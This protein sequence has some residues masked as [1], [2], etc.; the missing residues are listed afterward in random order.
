AALAD[1][2]LPACSY[3]EKDGT[4]TNTEGHVQQVR[5]AIE[6]I[7][8][9]RPDWEILSAL[10]VLM[11]YPLEYGESREILKEIRSLIPGYGLLGP[12]PTPPR[13][14]QTV[15]DRYLREGYAEDLASRYALAGEGQ[16]ARG[17]KKEEG[18]TLVVGPASSRPV[19]RACS[20]FR[21]PASL[22]SIQPTRSRLGSQRAIGSGSPTTRER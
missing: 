7:G 15:V 2:V 6:P 10:S 1:V 21:R 5:Q 11:G 17:S 9:S 19:R 12:T 22:G 13:L 4:V 16:A 3:A 18:F 20:R 14:D 8:E